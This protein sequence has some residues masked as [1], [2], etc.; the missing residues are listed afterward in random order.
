M[1]WQDEVWA[2]HKACFPEMLGSRHESKF[3]ALALCGEAGELAN[4]IAKR[5]RGEVS[6]IYA[7]PDVV[8]GAYTNPG[9]AVA[10]EIADVAIYLEML[11]RS[12]GIDLDDAVRRK[13]EVLEERFGPKAEAAADEVR[14]KVIGRQ[15]YSKDEAVTG[16]ITISREYYNQLK[17]KIVGPRPPVRDESP[18]DYPDLAEAGSRL[19]RLCMDGLNRQPD[20]VMTVTIADE[21]KQAIRVWDIAK[22]G[23]EK[24]EE[25]CRIVVAPEVWA[26]GARLVGLLRQAQAQKG[27]PGWGEVDGAIARWFSL[28]DPRKTS[29]GE[30]DPPEAVN[31]GQKSLTHAIDDE[32]NL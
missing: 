5:W 12:L 17:E 11:A 25:G 10:M 27:S 26:A 13:I 21:L 31:P 2:I 29:F 28:T 18:G 6:E 16:S 32:H 4:L 7:I 14:R 8:A 22:V 24:Q 19:A 23:V 1:S 30:P 20:A 9:G 15:V 3:L